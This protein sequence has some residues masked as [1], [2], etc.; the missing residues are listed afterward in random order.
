M[1]A[2]GL[3]PELPV[4][5]AEAERQLLCWAVT[6]D[7]FPLVFREIQPEHLH[8]GSHRKA[9]IALRGWM[10]DGGG[11]PPRRVQ[12]ICNCLGVRPVEKPVLNALRNTIQRVQ[13]SYRVRSQ[14][15]IARDVYAGVMAAGGAADAAEICRGAAQQ[16]DLLAR[17]GRH[18]L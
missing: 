8:R 16:L 2:W 3:P 10:L 14:Q 4:C 12:R 17:E 6:P 18:G 11:E 1:D 5:D 7:F 13:Q 15:R 9:Y